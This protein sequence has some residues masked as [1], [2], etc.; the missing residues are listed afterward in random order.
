MATETVRITGTAAGSY[1]SSVEA[2]GNPRS[3]YVNG[4]SGSE[5]VIVEGRDSS[6]NYFP[7]VQKDDSGPNSSQG[8]LGR[9]NNS[10]KIS[11]TVNFRISKGVTALSVEVGEWV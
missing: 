3:F 2:G 6:G 1:T 8:Y 4:L 10:I 7:L 5:R 9:T 11:P